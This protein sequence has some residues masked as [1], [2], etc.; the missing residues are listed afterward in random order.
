MARK[1]VTIDWMRSD[2]FTRSSPASRIR[3]PSSVKGAMAASTGISSMSAA[4][5]APAISVDFSCAPSTRTV[6]TSSP[7]CSSSCVI[8]MRTPNPIR[9]SS[10]RARVGFINN[11]SIT[12]SEP[13]NSD[14]AQKKNAALER[15]PG[16]RAS[17][18]CRRCPPTMQVELALRLRSAPNARRATSP[19]SRVRSGSSTSVSP[20]ANNPA[21]SKQDFTCALATGIL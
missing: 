7:F 8:E 16:M 2:S 15:S 17:I 1:L 12:S 20:L 13:G 10:R 9:I 14:A 21:N 3:I 5:S 18:A 11:E 19:W 6:P 4:E